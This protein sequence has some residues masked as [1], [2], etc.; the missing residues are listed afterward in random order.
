MK[1]LLIEHPRR[2]A[3]D[4]C[5]DIA[6]TPLSSCLLSG[7]AAAVLRRDGHEA[8]IVDG[9]L[10]R[11]SY[12]DILDRVIAEKPEVLAVHMVYNWE[13]NSPL[14]NFLEEVK[15]SLST[16]V[17]AFG[18][19]PTVAFRE[20]LETCPSIDACIAGEPELTLSRLAG[21]NLKPKSVSAIPGL[22]TRDGSGGLIATPPDAINDLD[23]IP[24]P[25]RT[26]G[27]LAMGEI[28]LLGSRGCY[29][30]CTFCYVGTFFGR[31]P[32]WRGRSP[33]NIAKEIDSL[34]AQTGSRDF[35]F[36]DPNF[37]G[38]G[39]GCQERAIR[40]AGLL[41]GRGIRFGI[42][43]RV[44]DIHDETIERLADAGLRHI[45]VGLE[46]GRDESLKRLNK[47]TT[48]VQNEEA[49]RILR[50]HAIEPNVGFIMFEPDS[51]LQ[52][53]RINFE[54][55]KRNDLFRRLSVTANVLYHHQIILQGTAA[56][57][58]L[59]A[60]GRLVTAGD[61]PYEGTTHFKNSAVATLAAIMR[62]VTNKLFASFD[63][64]WS[65]RVPEPE[66]VQV[67][68]DALNRLLVAVFEDNL[69][70]LESGEIL[71][72]GQA[73]A[74]VDEAAGKIEKTMETFFRLSGSPV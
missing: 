68:Y 56:Y 33:E 11:L 36:T 10:E 57:A 51:T 4:R 21:S 13:K 25:V 46:S 26:P 52:D 73:A 66:A 2:A 71:T 41:K 18:F 19:Y 54:F 1:V 16:Y 65:G 40:L 30:R 49:I 32:S 5:N 72:E 3:A 29:G 24:F 27:L 53:L 12:A 55:L 63:D 45:L 20:I 37:F 17:V 62:R 39:S 44:N 31:N 28:N 35:Y 38:P 59:K 34:M 22:V 69:T 6:N 23:T 8:E 9:Y 48:V 15:G 43:G 7:Y 67:A 58:Y 50:R 74:I 47:M 61:T 70:I 14:F 42:E 60:E 64:F